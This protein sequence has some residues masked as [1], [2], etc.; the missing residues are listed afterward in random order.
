MNVALMSQRAS[1]D[2][3]DP[4]RSHGGHR[5]VQCEYEREVKSMETIGTPT[6]TSTAQV[7][8]DVLSAAQIDEL[9]RAGVLD[10]RLLSALVGGQTEIVTCAVIATAWQRLRRS[11]SDPGSTR[12]PIHSAPQPRGRVQGPFRTE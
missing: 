10:R 3:G 8:V 4:A 1:P 6:V 9:G 12:W 11:R 5:G 2:A 7:L